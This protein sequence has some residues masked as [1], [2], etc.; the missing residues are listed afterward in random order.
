[1]REQGPLEYAPSPRAL[2]SL[3]SSE[4]GR[5]HPF[6][7]D[8]LHDAVMEAIATRRAEVELRR[9]GVFDVSHRL[10]RHA[11]EGVRA[12]YRVA[13]Q[14]GLATA[15]YHRLR[16]AARYDEDSPMLR[17]L[18]RDACAWAGEEGALVVDHPLLASALRAR[19]NTWFMH[20]EM[21]TPKEA[22]IR[23]VSRVFVPLEETA[24]E[25][26][27][28]GYDRERVRVT[29][30]CIEPGLLADAAA[31]AME[32]RVR[33]DSKE[34]LAAAFFSSGAE[35]I[36]H[37][38]AIAAAA[39]SLARG[40]HHAIVFA[41][42]GGRLE[43]ACAGGGGSA[44]GG[45]TEIV[46]FA[47]RAEL[48][49]VT[50]ERFPRFDLVVSPPHERSNWAVGLGVPFML[51]GPDIGPFAP[52]NRRLLLSLGVA[53]ELD[54]VRAAGFASFVGELRRSGALVAM[55]ERGERRP[56]DGFRRAAEILLDEA[57]RT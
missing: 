18:G 40:G 47:S 32:R 42:R 2:L 37:V 31:R 20:G 23:H 51:L 7:L 54:T 34:P 16:G 17:L 46:S 3:L 10:S 21:V 27:A 4:I 45:T 19:T 35:P 25:F 56:I 33:I 15:L 38:R 29:G 39:A 8:G 52:L 22:V 55:S 26:A 13:G 9:A 11:W 36:P 57:S 49:R 48:D 6:Y 50:A 14:G 1:M 24:E 5:G 44:G 43:R 41:A 53:H 12:A 28:H 30:I